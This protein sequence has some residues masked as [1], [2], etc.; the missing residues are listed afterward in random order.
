MASAPCTFIISNDNRE[1]S[2]AM[3]VWLVHKQDEGNVK[4]KN[5]FHKLYQ[6]IKS[7]QVPILDTLNDL[8]Y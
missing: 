5:E 2:E 6:N 8:T 1:D 3:A 4:K 7:K